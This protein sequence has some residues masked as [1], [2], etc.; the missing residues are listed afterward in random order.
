M[1]RRRRRQSLSVDDAAGGVNES[2]LAR[3]GEAEPSW[4]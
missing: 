2:E 1:D 4:A 3:A